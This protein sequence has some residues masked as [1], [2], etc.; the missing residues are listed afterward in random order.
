MKDVTA[1]FFSQPPSHR[2]ADSTWRSEKIASKL[3]QIVEIGQIWFQKLKMG[4]GFLNS[5]S[6]QGKQKLGSM[7]TIKARV[8]QEG[9][10]P[11]WLA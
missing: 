6:I 9:P 7:G 11:V 5:D 10:S 4:F 3:Q 1:Q 8:T 2:T